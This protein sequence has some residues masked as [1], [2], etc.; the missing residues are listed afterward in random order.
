VKDFSAETEEFPILEA[1]IRERLVK[2]Q[3]AGKYLAG[4]VVI[5]EAWRLVM[6]LQLLVVSSC[7]YKW[8]INPISNPKLRRQSHTYY[9]T[10]LYSCS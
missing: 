8:S 4:A 1:V 3:Q 5:C 6:A 9:V 10:I 2:S 7:V